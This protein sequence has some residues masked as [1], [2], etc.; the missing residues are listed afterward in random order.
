MLARKLILLGGRFSLSSFMARQAD[1][2]WLDTTR[3]NTLWQ[4]TAGTTPAVSVGDPI[5]RV[6]SLKSSPAHTV[7]Q[8][9][10]T[11]RPLLQTT[12]AKF[13]AS[14]DNWLTDYNAAAGAN[15]VVALVTVPASIAFNG[16][17]IGASEG[18]ANRCR[19]L[20]DTS[21][22]VC[23][24]LGTQAEATIVGTNDRRGATLVV[25]FSFSGSVVRLFDDAAIAYEA[26]QSGSPTT[27]VAFR[28]GAFNN[29]G[30]AVNQFGGSIK[31]L[32]V[33][34]QFLDLKTYL[35]LRSSLLAA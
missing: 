11:L 29:S 4:D 19:F 2:L 21:G 24:G 5:G 25:G 3:T 32:L 10:S 6:D 28:I 20:F 13:D 9:S 1:G 17:I 8:S 35:Q 15:F 23:A 12:G 22:R 31:R 33:G 26:A 16:A 14:D 34:R 27:S 30:T 7:L 18:A